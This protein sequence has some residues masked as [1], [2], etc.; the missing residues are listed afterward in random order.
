ME[1][2]DTTTPPAE[3]TP[4]QRA[5]LIESERPSP[6]IGIRDATFEQMFDELSGRIGLVSPGSDSVMMLSVSPGAAKNG[7]TVMMH[8][9][10]SDLL[11]AMID[12]IRT[13]AKGEPRIREALAMLLTAPDVR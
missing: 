6:T 4:E 1:T 8:G 10:A 2:T 11:P 13:K 7:T 9:R 12:S 3:M 5:A